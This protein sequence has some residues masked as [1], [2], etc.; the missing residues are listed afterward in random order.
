MT[1]SML[2]STPE[3]IVFNK[4]VLN[5]AAWGARPLLA[6]LLVYCS[7]VSL[8]VA[9]AVALISGVPAELLL[10]SF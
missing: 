5:D 3:S 9:A 1:M 10:A 2:P 6:G 7:T 4:T 8:S